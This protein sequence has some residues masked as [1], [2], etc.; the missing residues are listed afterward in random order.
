[1]IEKVGIVGGGQLGRMLTEAAHPLGFNVTVLDPTPN[2]PAAQ[3]GAKQI[4]GSLQDENAINELVKSNDVTTWEIEHINVHELRRLS[5]MDYNIQPNHETLETIQDKYFQKK[6]L[7][8]NGLP[9]ADF[10]LIPNDFYMMDVA[11]KRS[12]GNL[13]I[14]AA[15]GGYDGRGNLVY[16]GQSLDELHGALGSQIYAEGIV[17]FERELAVVAARDINGNIAIY[18][19]VET[20][21]KDNICHT[22]IAPAEVST[23][24]AENAREIAHETLRHLGGAG[25]FAIEMFQTDEEVLINE[26]APR[27]HNSGHITIEANTTSQFEQHIRAVTGMPLGDTKM[28]APAA[29]MINILGNKAEPLSRKGLENVLAMPDTHPHFYGKDPRPARKIGHITVLG[30]SINEVRERAQT[31]REALKI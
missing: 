4:E 3:V 2:C 10:W 12:Q 20:V 18:P 14:K 23:K 16:A 5:Y 30:S 24:V 27:V 29:A 9:V 25:I 22:V 19:T 28:R 26:I 6:F 7:K 31:A 17:D 13:I 15:T 1:M 21:H 8:D 11:L